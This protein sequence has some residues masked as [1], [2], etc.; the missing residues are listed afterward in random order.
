MSKFVEEIRTAAVG[1]DYN[2][3]ELARAQKLGMN[4]MND[5]AMA[6][7]RVYE[8]FVEDVAYMG[9]ASVGLG[10]L[11]NNAAVTPASATTGD[12]MGGTTTPTQILA[13]INN[14]ITGVYVGSKTVEFA[15]T[16]LL[17]VE[18]YEYI[19]STARSDTSDTTILGY[20]KANNSYHRSHGSAAHR[21]TVPPAF[22]RGRRQ[23]GSDGHLPPR[24]DILKLHIP[25]PLRFWPAQQIVFRFEVPGMFRMGGVEIRRPSAVR[26]LDGI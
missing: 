23:Y 22:G 16:V 18:E 7:R 10:G 24:P 9:D 2:I 6:A 8:E 3:Q 11:L 26:F 4:L 1:Y 17:P 12:W 21:R 13:D 19:A 15:D 14:G 20:L 5:R 25:M